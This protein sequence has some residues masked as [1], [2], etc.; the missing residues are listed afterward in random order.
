LIDIFRIIVGTNE[1][2]TLDDLRTRDEMNV[3]SLLLFDHVG[4][5]EG[6]ADAA[7]QR[8]MLP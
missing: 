6:D 4:F 7:G 2:E 1:V 8:V 5:F 3:E